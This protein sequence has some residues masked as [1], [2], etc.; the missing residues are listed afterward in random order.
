MSN[1]VEPDRP[2]TTKWRM[3]WMLDTYGC[4]HAFSIGNTPF[5]LQ[6]WFHERASLLRNT[7]M[8]ITCHARS[9]GWQ[10][11]ENLYT[12]S[13]WCR[14][15]PIPSACPAINTALICSADQ[16]SFS[17]YMIPTICAVYSDGGVSCVPPSTHTASC[18]ADL[19]LWPYDRHTCKLEMGSWTHTGEKVNVSLQDPSVRK[20]KRIPFIFNDEST[21]SY[22]APKTYTCQHDARLKRYY[23]NMRY[24]GL[25]LF[26]F[27]S[28]SPSHNPLP[29]MCL[30]N[31]YEE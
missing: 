2:Q 8:Y 4:K 17:P 27:V 7:S 6:Q 13:A 14:D 23:N 30:R 31:A 10:K 21:G 3:H 9:Y 25:L 1:V 20:K 5:P 18:S 19:T 29:H 22:M 24:S 11:S 15:A 28:R 12:R 16:S 26:F